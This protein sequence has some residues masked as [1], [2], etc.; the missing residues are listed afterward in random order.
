MITRRH[1]MQT[2]A[3]FIAASTFTVKALAKMATPR[4]K[5][6]NMLLLTS[7]MFIGTLEVKITSNP[8]AQ[9]NVRRLGQINPI[10]TGWVNTFGGMYRWEATQ[11][12]ELVSLNDDLHIYP[13]KHVD[14]TMTFLDPKT[15][16]TWVR[17]CRNRKV[18]RLIPASIS[19]E[20]TYNA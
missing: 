13:Q 20:T 6:G 14:W 18:G 10:L 8:M 4:K 9:V 19:E 2:A 5:P 1:F 7:V 16:W 15:G 17:S 3:T 12:Q 11:G